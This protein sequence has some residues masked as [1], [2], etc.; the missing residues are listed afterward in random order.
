VSWERHRDGQLWT[1]RL[2][3]AIAALAI[4]ALKEGT[5]SRSVRPGSAGMHP[6]WRW[7]TAALQR[8]RPRN[9][10]EVIPKGKWTQIRGKVQEWWGELTDDDLGVIE[11]R[12]NR[13]VGKLQERY[14][15]AKQRAEDEVA[16]RLRDYEDVEPRMRSRSGA[17]DT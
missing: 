11:G 4:T 17:L 6:C 12:L 15:W 14:G 16:R 5:P 7:R 2:S 1:S 13:L 8:T 10:N 9:E 3:P